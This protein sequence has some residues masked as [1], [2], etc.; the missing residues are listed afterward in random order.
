MHKPE[1]TR[2]VVARPLF[3]QALGQQREI[4]PA[5]RSWRHEH[6]DG[7]IEAGPYCD[8]APLRA[9]NV[10]D[11]RLCAHHSPGPHVNVPENQRLM[12]LHQH[13]KGLN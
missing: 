8:P 3:T 13:T 10:N 1:L 4:E 11:P 7:L 6:G 12:D 5:T 2:S 9:V